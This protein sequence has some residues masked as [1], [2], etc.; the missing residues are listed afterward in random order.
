M[1]KKPFDLWISARHVRYTYIYFVYGSF[2]F[3]FTVKKANF[4]RVERGS[5]FDNTAQSSVVFKGVFEERRA[6]R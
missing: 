6:K 5:D 1:R 3:F 4:L 2:F